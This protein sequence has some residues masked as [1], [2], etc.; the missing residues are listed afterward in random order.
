MIR[1]FA[2]ESGDLETGEVL[3]AAFPLFTPGP[4]SNAFDPLRVES[5]NSTSLFGAGLIDGISASRIT[6]QVGARRWSQLRKELDGSF[7]GGAVGRPRILADGR[8]GK[9][10]WKAQFA[11]L[12]EFVASACANELGLGNPLIPQAKPLGRADTKAPTGAQDLGARELRSLVSYVGLLPRP[13]EVVPANHA[14]RDRAGRGKFL[15]RQ[16]GCADC[17]TPSIDG[18]E[19]VYSDLLLHSLE[20]RSRGGGGYGHHNMQPVPTPEDHP[21]PDEW[22]TPPLWGVADS[23]PYFHD[24]ASPTL[25]M[26]IV[27]HQGDAADVTR[28]YQELSEPDREAVVSFLQTLRAPAEAEPA[29][30]V[31]RRSLVLAP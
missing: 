22:R 26:A 28:N 16:I 20:D 14:A 12:E 18:V 4:N 25:A 19:G 15:F 24:G 10:G 23:A 1:K 8:V 29:P 7:R 2:V 6:A 11:T 9:F 17:H 30:S 31:I 27:R 3:R 21:Q 5:I 13:V